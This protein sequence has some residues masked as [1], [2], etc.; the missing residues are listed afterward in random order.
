MAGSDWLASFLRRH[1]E[2]SLMR[3][4]PEAMSLAKA[5]SFNGH[6]VELFF[7]NLEKLLTENDI[8]LWS[9]WSM[10]ETGIT[11]VQRPDRIIPRRERKQIGAITSQERGEIVTIAMAVSALGNSVPPFFIFPRYYRTF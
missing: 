7:N 10:D 6:N 8:P 11:T 5:S 9:I 1:K 2:L 4:K 3:N